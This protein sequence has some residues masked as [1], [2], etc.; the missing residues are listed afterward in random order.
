MSI[1]IVLVDDHRLFRAG[2]LTMLADH[3][4]IEVVGEAEDGLEGVK[5]VAA[6]RPDLVLMDVS[7]KGMS[8]IEATRRILATQP[9]TKVLCLS[10]H[11]EKQFV[12]AVLEAGASGYLLKDSSVEELVR[13][14][15]ALMDG[16]TYLSPPV[17][18]VVVA[19]YTTRLAEKPQSP[20]T[21]LTPREREVL[22]LISE[23]HGTADIATRLHVSGKTVGS[24][25]EHLMKKLDIHSVA[26]LTKYAIRAGFTSVDAGPVD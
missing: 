2:V 7:M 8:G 14:I 12:R 26:G 20:N 22:Q 15:R 6:Q 13:A 16:Q 10:M 3:S 4:D 18:G 23:G 19:D 5:L 24:H 25:R 11:G 9:E 1:R 17:A 21:L